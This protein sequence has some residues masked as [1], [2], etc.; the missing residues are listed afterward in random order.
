M[1]HPRGVTLIELLV[2]LAIIGILATVALPRMGASF[3]RMR[4]GRFSRSLMTAHRAARFKALSLQ[5]PVQVHYNLD[6]QAVRFYWYDHTQYQPNTDRWRADNWP[7]ERS[8]SPTFAPDG[9]LLDSVGSLSSGHA[10]VVFLPRGT[11][12]GPYE[13]NAP[14]DHVCSQS[15]A[16]SPGVHVTWKNHPGNDACEWNTIRLFTA[17]ATVKRLEYGAY[18]TGLKNHTESS[19]PGCA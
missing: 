11:M 6:A 8:L 17:T 5:R 4:V 13:R 15:N 16:E 14:D 12:A 7:G 3:D 18:G 19:P 1:S 10:C 9:V 2:V